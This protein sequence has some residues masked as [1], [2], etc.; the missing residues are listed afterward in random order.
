MVPEPAIFQT[1][2]ATTRAGRGDAARPAADSSRLAG[3]ARAGQQLRRAGTIAGMRSRWRTVLAGTLALGALAGCSPS[4]RGL[5]GI[6]LDADHQPVAVLG[7]CGDFGTATSIILYEA[8]PSGGVH[9]RRAVLERTGGDTPRYLEVPLAAPPP[10]W[11]VDV[12]LTNLADTGQA[13]ELRAWNEDGDNRVGSFPF[14]VSE[15]GDGPDADRTI[16]TKVRIAATSGA[17][18][19]DSVFLT[20]AEF[21]QRTEQACKASPMAP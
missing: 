5:S 20:P 4:V 11:R 14:R 12:A 3:P 10:G 9:K 21:R 1:G 13:Y 16:L 8:D 7:L 18:R 2:D 15:L 6:R 17:D 19:Y